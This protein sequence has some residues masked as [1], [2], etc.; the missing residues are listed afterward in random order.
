MSI[1][2]HQDETFSEIIDIDQDK[3]LLIDVLEDNSTIL[4]QGEFYF[5]VYVQ[6]F[7]KAYI[8]Y[9]I[10]FRNSGKTKLVSLKQPL[11]V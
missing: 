1:F 2:S 8:P 9:M 5:T 3:P 10:K 7:C 6:F 4:A 11:M